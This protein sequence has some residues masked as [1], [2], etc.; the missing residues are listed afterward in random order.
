MLEGRL[1]ITLD[2]KNII[3]KAGDPSLILPSRV[4]HSMKS[5]KGEKVHFREQP[6]PPGIYKAL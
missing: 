5:F 2:G 3:L 4:V 1:E 6:D